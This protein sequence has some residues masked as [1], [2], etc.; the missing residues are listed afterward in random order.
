VH[1]PIVSQDTFQRCADAIAAQWAAAAQ[2]VVDLAGNCGELMGIR[3]N[4]RGSVRY[5]SFHCRRAATGGKP[6]DGTQ[7]RVFD[8]DHQVEA[9]F[10]NPPE[11][12]PPRRGRPPVWLAELHALS[13]VFPILNVTAQHRVVRDS[14]KEVIWNSD[15]DRIRISF[16]EA[17]LVRYSEQLLNFPREVVM[18]VCRPDHGYQR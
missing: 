9:I 16:N 1:E 7:V 2:D 11:S 8:I 4:S 18:S 12:L 10:R 3:T 14:V 17:A 15:S 13:Q 6:C 5:V